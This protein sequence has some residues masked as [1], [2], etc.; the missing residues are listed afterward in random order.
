[1]SHRLPQ[2]PA[3]RQVNRL[4]PLRVALIY[5]AAAL[6][7]IVV[8]DLAAD[9]LFHESLNVQLFKGAAFV[10]ITAAVLYGLLRANERRADDLML[11]L[12]ESA[13]NSRDGF[14]QWDLKRDVIT[15]TPGG[16]R[17]LGWEAAKTIASKAG[18]GDVVHPDDWPVVE[19]ALEPVVAGRRREFMVDHRVHAIDGGWIW[20]RVRGQ[21]TETDRD[22]GPSVVSGT[23]TNVD[24]LKRRELALQRSNRAL[25]SIV[26]VNRAGLAAH[27]RDS[28]LEGVCRALASAEDY[29]LVW[30]GVAEEGGE[31]RVRAIASSGTAS[32]FLRQVRIE[33]GR[34]PY[35]DGPT[36]RALRKGA[37]E[38]VDDARVVDHCQPW[39]ED[40]ARYEIRSTIAI[41][42]NDG[43]RKCVLHIDSREAEAFSMD[44]A[45]AYQALAQDLA[46]ALGVFS[47]RESYEQRLA[48][49]LR[50]TVAALAVT[51]EKR[52]PYTGGH[53]N[54]VGE[55]A[56]EIAQEMDV[57]PHLIEGIRLGAAMHDIGKI[58]VPVE[59][60]TKPGKL[61]EGEM[62]L[63]RRHPDIGYDI[64]KEIDFGWPVA[65]IVRQH[66]ERVDGS[67]Y[68][69]GLKADAIALEARIV[70]VADVIESMATHRPY[71]PALPLSVVE[72]ELRKGR[73]VRYDA[74]VVDAALRV[75][76]HATLEPKIG[77]SILADAS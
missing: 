11:R 51:V 6:A 31:K 13:E 74:D 42:F 10:G 67:G 7:W 5:C 40:L 29:V 70:A 64:V 1:M 22:G 52:D 34:G 36:G 68:P 49:A 24:G 60:L 15:V 58:G 47:T 66:H 56:V 20:Y 48:Q 8:S 30:V 53:Q 2:S 21:V 69:Q 27:D 55:L 28:L 59:I 46:R 62:A 57:S 37:P 76:R 25:D 71:R 72:E 14:W 73:G 44:E 54:R 4:G 35:G 12:R 33:W 18:W 39:R 3:R 9:E 41:P 50:G 45:T 77:Q 65:E 19:A 32:D 23:Y 63:V 61:D 43:D 16:D 26:A 75:L 38:V 17:D